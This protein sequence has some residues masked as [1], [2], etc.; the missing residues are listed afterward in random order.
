MPFFTQINSYLSLVLPIYT[1]RLFFVFVCVCVFAHVDTKERAV[2]MFTP[3]RREFVKD[4]YI[5]IL[6]SEIFQTEKQLS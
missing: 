5:M 4:A 6:S 2:N 3:W 1:L